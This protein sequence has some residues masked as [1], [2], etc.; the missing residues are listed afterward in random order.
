MWNSDG[1]KYVSA[2][3][4]VATTAKVPMEV[5][6][7]DSGFAV[8][9]VAVDTPMKLGICLETAASGEIVDVALAGYISGVSVGASGLASTAMS[10]FTN[11][12]YVFWTDTG[13]FAAGGAT[14]AANCYAHSTVDGTTA[15]AAAGIALS[16]GQ[17]ATFNLLLLEK[18]FIT[19]VAT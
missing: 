8:Q 3:A 12:D 17:T 11:G 15:Y 4:L 9:A 13:T 14:W 2:I 16:S 19:G 6:P 7:T 1:Q 5:I 10:T 18:P